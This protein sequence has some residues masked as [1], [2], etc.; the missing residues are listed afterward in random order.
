MEYVDAEVAVK[1]FTPHLF[2]GL[3]FS[4]DTGLWDGNNYLGGEGYL[5]DCIG[6]DRGV[7]MFVLMFINSVVCEVR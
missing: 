6:V 5:S 7:F 4:G 3:I 1:V 2:R